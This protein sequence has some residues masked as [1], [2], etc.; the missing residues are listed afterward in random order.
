MK[1]CMAVKTITITTQAYDA[2]KRRKESRE[3]F[4]QAILRLTKKT[5]LDQF[6][7]ILTEKEGKALEKTIKDM[8][9]VNTRLHNA[10]MERIVNE[11]KP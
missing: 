1:Q 4:S 8:R 2:L 7:G 6:F 10:R 5:T 11:M 3:S 9:V